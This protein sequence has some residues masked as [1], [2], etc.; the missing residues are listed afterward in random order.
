MAAPRRGCN[1][2]IHGMHGRDLGEGCSFTGRVAAPRDR[3]VGW[4][5]HTEW[6]GTAATRHGDCEVPPC[7]PRLRV[8]ISDRIRRHAQG[9]DALLRWGKR[10]PP[11]GKAKPSVG[12]SQTPRWGR[13]APPEGNTA[14][15]SR[16]T[17]P[18]QQGD[19]PA[20]AGENAPTTNQPTTNQP[21]TTNYQLPPTNY[22][23][24]MV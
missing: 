23:P 24:N 8:R 14:R 7:S 10:N 18:P 5:F 9:G 12:G 17:R 4:F 1:H 3:C 2:G 13:P 19:S 16:G 20:P 21:T 6:S 22:Q 15:P 11:L